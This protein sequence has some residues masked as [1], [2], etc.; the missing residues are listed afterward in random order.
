MVRLCR[1]IRHALFVRLS[2]LGLSSS[3]GM[4]MRAVL[5]MAFLFVVLQ[6]ML[7]LAS[8]WT[9]QRVSANLIDRQLVPI[10]RMQSIADH[11]QTAV[12]VANKVRAGTMTKASGRS[13]MS[14]L[15]A[16]LKTDW[17]DLSADPP[18]ALEAARERRSG[19]DQAMADLERAISEDSPDRLDF[20]LSGGLYG[21]MD[22]LLVELRARAAGLRQEAE[23]D[24]RHLGMTVL[25]AQGG[26]VAMLLVAAA[27]GAWLMRQAHRSIIDPLVAIAAHAEE[28][29]AGEVPYQHFDDEVGGIARAISAARLRASE[30]RRLLEERQAAAAERRDVERR[31]A[32]AARRRAAMLDGV[33]SEFGEALSAMVEELSAAA[34]Q[35]GDMADGMSGTAERAEARA[36]QLARSFESAEANISRIEEA[37]GVMLDIGLDVGQRTATSLDRGG[38]VHDQSRHNRAHALQLREMVAQISGALD[39]ISSIARQTNLL[40][41]NAG[42]EARRA[43]EAGRGFAVVAAEVK[44]LSHDAQSA[45]HE[46]GRKLDMVRGTADKVLDSATAVE[47]LAQEIARESHAAADAVEKHKL[48]SH[49]IVMSLGGARGEMRGTAEAMNAL[50]GDASDVRRS[51]QNVQSTSRAVARRAA[52]LR[53]RFDALTRGVREAA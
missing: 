33:F 9:V 24:R 43:G 5:A 14:S 18:P 16:A 21:S 53:E 42:I 47:T 15:T 38:K 31:A 48:A 37:S 7:T 39:L 40:A 44:S 41:L 1:L 30:H 52:E 19:A 32:D 46:I 29:E 22:P 2:S 49:S 51:S 35:M 23:T 10:S 17:D 6:G 4:R 25:G 13:E 45:A 27:V 36:V 26:L 20:L 50:H 8:L 28:R 3:L 11:Y 12:A 34:G